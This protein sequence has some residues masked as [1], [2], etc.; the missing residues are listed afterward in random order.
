MSWT[1]LPG[2][3]GPKGPIPQHMMLLFED[4]KKLKWDRTNLMSSQDSAM[5]M[6]VEYGV[7]F[8]EGRRKYW[9]FEFQGQIR[10]R[11][12][13]T[14]RGQVGTTIQSY[15]LAAGYGGKS[16][17]ELYQPSPSRY[18]QKKIRHMD[19]LIRLHLTNSVSYILGLEDEP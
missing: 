1:G 18:I 3:P 7:I 8:T 6:G 2:T 9:V 13:P 17:K 10:F 11:F 14:G 12:G 5:G 19:D 15:G 16:L 4:I